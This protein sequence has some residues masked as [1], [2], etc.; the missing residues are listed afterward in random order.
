MSRQEEDSPT[1]S[2]KSGY[3][4]ISGDRKSTNMKRSRTEPKEENPKTCPRWLTAED[5]S[6]IENPDY[7][8]SDEEEIDWGGAD[9]EHMSTDSGGCITDKSDQNPESED[10]NIGKVCEGLVEVNPLVYKVC[11]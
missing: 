5:G 7:V 10:N 6:R 3:G 2:R 11:C 8:N 4:R 9:D 1:N